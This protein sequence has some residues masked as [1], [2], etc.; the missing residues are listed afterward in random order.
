MQ[1]IDS[2]KARN[3]QVNVTLRRVHVNIVAVKS[4][5]Y[6]LLHLCVIVCVCV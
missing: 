6:Y 3:V 1:K 5:K 2:N 4:N